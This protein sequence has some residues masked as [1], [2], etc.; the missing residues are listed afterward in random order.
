MTSAE[1]VEPTR[2]SPVVRVAAALAILV[3]LA[4]LFILTWAVVTGAFTSDDGPFR[5]DPAR[6]GTTSGAA[7]S[8]IRV[9]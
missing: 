3:I 7:V 4:A 1:P 2:R 5:D 6:N 8:T 9:T